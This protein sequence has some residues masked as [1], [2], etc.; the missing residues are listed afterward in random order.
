MSQKKMGVVVVNFFLLIFLFF[1]KIEKKSYLGK[2]LI[3]FHQILDLDA[4]FQAEY[5]RKKIWGVGCQ[6]GPYGKQ[7]VLGL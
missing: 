1:E 3:D 6:G 4:E 2:G 5:D 7:K